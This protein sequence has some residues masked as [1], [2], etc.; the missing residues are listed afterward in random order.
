ME[1]D[2]QGKRDGCGISSED[3]VGVG[4]EHRSSF[5]QPQ[6]NQ[7]PVTIQF[8]S[9]KGF[10]SFS[11]KARIGPLTGFS[12]I[13]G[14]NGSGKSVIGEALA[15][16]FGASPRTMRAKNVIA[17]LNESTKQQS[18]TEC[19]KVRHAAAEK[20]IAE[21]ENQQK[22]EASEHKKKQKLLK[23]R[24]ETLSKEIDQLELKKASLIKE[25]DSL[26]VEK[27]V[28]LSK[29]S[30]FEGQGN[31]PGILASTQEELT[32][33]DVKLVCLKEE[34]RATEQHNALC[35]TREAEIIL[36]IS[37]LEKDMHDILALEKEQNMEVQSVQE[38]L[39]IVMNKLEDIKQNKV[40]FL[41]GDLS[42]VKIQIEGLQSK[43]N[44]DWSTRTLKEDEAAAFLK[45]QYKGRVHGR[46]ADLG[47]ITNDIAKP[48]NAI[49][50]HMTNMATTFVTE[51]RE[52]AN[53][54]IYHFQRNRIGIV[55]CVILSEANKTSR[56]PCIFQHS[57]LAKPVL[58]YVSCSEKYLPVFAR[59]LQNW[60]V[61]SDRNAATQF[62]QHR[63]NQ[64]GNLNVVTMA[65]DLFKE[66]GEIIRVHMKKSG[67]CLLRSNSEYAAE[68]RKACSGGI[69]ETQRILENLLQEKE[70][71]E[72]GITSEERNLEILQVE[73]RSLQKHLHNLIIRVTG[74]AN[75]KGSLQNQLTNKKV[76]LERIRLFDF[77]KDMKIKEAIQHL[78][79][80]REIIYTKLE[81]ERA[82]S[83][84]HGLFEIERKTVTCGEEIQSTDFQIRQTRTV[85]NE[86]HK[87]VSEEFESDKCPICHKKRETAVLKEELRRM[88]EQLQHEE[89][90]RRG[91]VSELNQ[92]RDQL[93]LLEA[94]ME[95]CRKDEKI[96]RKQEILLSKRVDNLLALET[97]AKNQLSKVMQALP[98][99]VVQPPKRPCLKERSLVS[100][101]EMALNVQDEEGLK[102]AEEEMSL[103]EAHRTINGDALDEDLRCRKR[104][105]TLTEKLNHLT[106]RISEEK[107]QKDELEITRYI[108]FERAMK[109]VNMALSKVYGKLTK[110]G[111]AYLTYTE[112]KSLLFLDGVHLH[113]RPDRHK[114]RS[115]SSLSGGQQAL[116]AL[117]LSFSLQ[118][119]FPSPF[120]FFD[121]V[122]ASLDTKNAHVVADY[123]KNKRSAQYIVV[124]H[125]PQVYELASTLVGVYHLFGGSASVS[126]SFDTSSH[127]VSKETNVG[128]YQKNA[129]L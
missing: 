52:A 78:T 123:I 42:A 125:R 107:K 54:V 6:E 60:V 106:E 35:A 92:M 10:K 47:S 114:W 21:L 85:V 45:E 115:F 120:Y 12:C 127:P 27:M 59:Y 97:K 36:Q 104:L 43:L 8:I 110:H 101:E 14:P 69:T 98:D 68:D 16:A 9:I 22:K 30:A 112:E 44:K 3:R 32:S 48:V 70:Q 46:L 81:D 33:I 128:T 122:D 13:I 63:K 38:K 25:K 116:V 61:V 91:R 51:D 53:E 74:S 86:L 55:T 19:A 77:A 26:D 90:E 117:A 72:A 100:M 62:F 103:N 7:A 1:V 11:Q 80:R 31:S 126:V 76:E 28:F 96:T 99:P 102:L 111:D 118:S 124:S 18:S 65:G 75:S 23:K 94:D 20:K 93:A 49:L 50:C 4:I 58:S 129:E 41:R 84:L 64:P 95:K 17:L 83:G 113:V 56:H 24:S 105:L 71:L 119:A 87:Q 79:D 108:T 29:C 67:H 109:K 2:K 88:E 73:E 57:V 5:V 37:T 82:Q 121:E 39:S 34:L 15:F 40:P 66:D 89:T